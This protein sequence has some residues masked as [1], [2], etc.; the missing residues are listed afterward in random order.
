MHVKVTCWLGSAVCQRSAT[1]LSVISIFYRAD[2]GG[3]RWSVASLTSSSGY[4]THTP[5][6]SSYSVSITNY[7]VCFISCVV[8]VCFLICM[9]V[10]LT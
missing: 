7:Y 6:S 1:L 3:R 4:G 10:I 2:V 5:C 8:L 9:F